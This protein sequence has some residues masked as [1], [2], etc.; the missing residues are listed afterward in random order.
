GLVSALVLGSA[1]GSDD[2]LLVI[3]ATAS[4]FAAIWIVMSGERWWVPMGFGLGIGGWFFVPFKL[5]PHELALAL[6]GMAILPRIPFKSIGLRRKR[7]QLP[8]VFYIL[9]LYLL[10]H[11]AVAAVRGWDSGGLGN[12]AR[13]Y[14]NALWPFIIGLAVYLYGSTSV[15]GAMLRAMYL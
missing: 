12:I 14:L 6:C 4:L 13:A 7:P 9:F 3:L 2:Y 15:V 11:F 10:V 5:Y 1:L 8:K